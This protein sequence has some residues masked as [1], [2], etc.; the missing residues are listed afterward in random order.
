VEIWNS[1]IIPPL[2]I[3]SNVN[4]ISLDLSTSPN[5]WI[6]YF[7]S[8]ENRH[9]LPMFT[10]LMNSVCA[11]DPV[12]MGLPYNHLLFSDTVEPLV[13][14]ALQILIVTLDHDTSHGDEVSTTYLIIIYHKHTLGL[15]W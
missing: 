4:F 1:M 14:A 2:F 10:S 12:G 3:P 8:A 9:A 15:L 13:D 5:K 11:Y 7:T 6:Q